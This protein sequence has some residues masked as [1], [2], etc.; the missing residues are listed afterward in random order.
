MFGTLMTNAII[1]RRM[2]DGSLKI[3]PYDKARLQHCHY[4][5]SPGQLVYEKQTGQ[6][7]K[8][9]THNLSDDPYTLKAHEYVI[10]IP[11]ERIVL[12]DGIV[13]LFVPES[14]LIEEGFSVTTGKL[15]PGYGNKGEQLRFG[16][17]NN[18]GRENTYGLKSPLVHVQFFDISGLALL[19]VMKG[20]REE[21]LSKL[22]Q[23]EN[24]EKR[25]DELDLS[26][27]GSQSNW[28]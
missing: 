5:L 7:W 20:T 23:K 2:K 24:A 9:R 25:E 28:R 3:N 18:L 13:G 12:P 22:R 11:H 15:D 10:V 21:M 6:D 4:R 26:D 19:E 8:R 1:D 17:Q 16:L 14:R 27:F